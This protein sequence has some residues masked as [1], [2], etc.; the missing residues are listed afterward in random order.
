MFQ[1]FVANLNTRK[2]RPKNVKPI[3]CTHRHGRQ[4]DGGVIS[5]IIIY[6]SRLGPSFG[7]FSYFFLFFFLSFLARPAYEPRVCVCARVIMSCTS[8]RVCSK[9]YGP[10]RL[11]HFTFVLTC[12]CLGR[13]REQLDAAKNNNIKRR[14]R[15]R[16]NQ[17]EKTKK[18]SRPIRERYAGGMRSR[19]TADGGGSERDERKIAHA[20][21]I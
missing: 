21:I 14:R 11:T 6:Y 10:G 4:G 15:R 3:T 19:N 5:T 18:K 17:R 16:R 12:I 20:L 8:V 9:L 7:F 1:K 13:P 2:S